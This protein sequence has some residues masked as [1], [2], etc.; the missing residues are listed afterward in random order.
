[1]PFVLENIQNQHDSENTIYYLTLHQDIL[2][3]QNSKLKHH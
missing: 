3:S 1:M 2:H